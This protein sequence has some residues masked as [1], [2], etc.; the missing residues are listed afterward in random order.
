MRN[1]LQIYY[2]VEIVHLIMFWVYRAQYLL[3]NPVEGQKKT[4]FE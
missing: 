3:F 4:I 1:T 2:L